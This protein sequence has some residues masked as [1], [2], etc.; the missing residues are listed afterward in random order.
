MTLTGKQYIAG[1]ATAAGSRTFRGINPA[2]GE[3]LATDFY[4]A[5]ESEVDCAARAA[6]N[7][8]GAFRDTTPAQRANFLRSVA[9]EIMALGDT[10]VERCCAESG[11]PAGRIQGERG[12]TVNQLRLFAD[13]VEEGS[14]VDARIDR[15]NPDREPLP[16]P[17]VRSMLRP[18]G[19]VAV[20][21]ASNFPLAFSVAGGD[22]A[23]ALAA[24]CPVV[25]KGHPSHPGTCELIATA[26]NSAVQKA[27]LPAGVFSLIQGDDHDSGMWL[28]KHPAIQAV[29]FTGSYGG[30]TAL[31]RAANERKQ[32]IPVYAEMGSSNPVFILPNALRERG[33]EIAK[34]LTQSVTLG[35]GQFCTNPGLVF[36]PPNGDTDAFTQA[37]AT[38]FRGVDAAVMLNER[39]RD[40]Y[41]SGV[42]RLRGA[43]R[44]ELVGEGA[45]GNGG[46]TG[47]ARL[48]AASIDRYLA[49]TDLE[50]EVFGPSSVLLSGGSREQLLESARRLGGHLT[51]TLFGTPEDL[52]Q[53]RDLITIL[54]QKAGRLIINNFPTG[55]EVCHSMV[56][57]GPFPA[58][59]DSRT[60]SVGTRA[61]LRFARPVCFQNFPDQLLPPALREKNPLSIH[62]MI[63]G[64][65]QVP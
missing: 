35:V 13:V 60:T 32:P 19:P 8:F 4:A 33:Q 48:F 55:V 43:D 6:G 54:E 23:S 63:D 5:T 26:I 20:F 11:L 59:T 39:I 3:K 36:L 14:W 42:D 24:G 49:D 56:H 25:A 10:L 62:R 7:A 64:V 45:T 15:A 65:R 18:L 58:T 12:R 27:E 53:H 44:V 31:F 57:G 37:V 2:N 52:E 40:A 16:K 29:G 34:G 30:G 1:E 51:V 50:E 17:D 21:G 22:T 61:I 46:Y 38:E 47:Q 41:E 9:E 28:V